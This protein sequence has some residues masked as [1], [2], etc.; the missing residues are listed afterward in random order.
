M[1]AHCTRSSNLTPGVTLAPEGHPPSPLRPQP[2]EWE[3]LE[4]SGTNRRRF[5]LAAGAHRPQTQRSNDQTAQ[6]AAN[7]EETRHKVEKKDTRE[8]AE[9]LDQPRKPSSEVAHGYTPGCT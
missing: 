3:W 9:D 6:E 4:A 1:P 2:L 8:A 5:A 7:P